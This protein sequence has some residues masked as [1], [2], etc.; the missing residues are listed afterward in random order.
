MSDFKNMC[1]PFPNIKVE[2]KLNMHMRK[3]KTD[4]NK[5]PL[6]WFPC[7]S[8]EDQKPSTF[9]SALCITSFTVLQ[10]HKM[11]KRRDFG[12]ET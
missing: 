11:L 8:V 1:A 2:I 9:G 7:K 6:K 10:N 4:F 5:E 3:W 12:G